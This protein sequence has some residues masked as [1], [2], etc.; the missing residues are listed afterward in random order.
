MSALMPW[1]TPRLLTKKT[2]KQTKNSNS[3]H[4]RGEPLVCV[5]EKC[6]ITAPIS[7]Y[8]LGY[9][10]FRAGLVCVG[11]SVTILQELSLH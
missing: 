10:E 4:R 8:K 11:L 6:N 9:C 7:A 3:L 1:V 2:N 5:I